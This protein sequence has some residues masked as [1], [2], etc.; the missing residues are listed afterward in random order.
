MIAENTIDG[1]WVYNLDQD[2]FT[3]LNPATARM[4]GFPM[5]RLQEMKLS[6][7]LAPEFRERVASHIAEA[8]RTLAAESW[9]SISEVLELRQPTGSGQEI[10]VEVSARIRRNA[11]GETEILAV[12]RNIESRKQT[13]REVLSLSYQDALTGLRNRRSMEEEL[14]RQESAQNLPVSVLVG[15]VDGL[16]HVNDSLGHE[17]GDEMLVLAS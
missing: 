17:M 4:L 16:K 14:L 9:E 5:D 11:R 12:S 1:I 8:R 13:E 6:D 15:D 2:R 10:W 7:G 3:Y